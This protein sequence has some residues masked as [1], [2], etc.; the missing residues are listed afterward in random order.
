MSQNNRRTSGSKFT[1]C[2][3]ASKIRQLEKD[4]R[5]M[6][7]NNRRTSGSKF[8]GCTKA[9][10]IRQLESALDYAHRA[11]RSLN[12][13][14]RK[15]GIENDV[16]R[17]GLQDENRVLTEEQRNAELLLKKQDEG[18][19]KAKLQELKLQKVFIQHLLNAVLEKC[20]AESQTCSPSTKSI[21][22]ECTTECAEADVQAT[23]EVTVVSVETQT[24]AVP[25]RHQSRAVRAWQSFCGQG[26]D[27]RKMSQ[28]NRRT[29]GSKFT[30]CPKASKIRQLESALDYAHRAIRSLNKELRK[31]G[32]ENDVLRSGLQDENRVLTEEQRNAELLLK[33][34]DEGRKKAKLQELK[35]Q[36]VFIQ[37]LLNAVLEKV[38]ATSAPA[39]AER[40]EKDLGSSCGKLQ[41]EREAFVSQIAEQTKSNAA[42]DALLAELKRQIGQTKTRPHCTAE[43]QT[44]SPS[45]KS[46]GSECTTECAEADVQATCEVTVVVL[47]EEQRNAELLLKKQDEGRKKAKLQELKLQKVF[48]QHL[49]NAVLEKVLATSAPA[50]AERMEKDLGSSC[51][52]LQE[53]REAFV[54]QIAEQTKSNAAKDALLAEL[55]RQIGTRPHCTAESQTCSPS[56]KSIG[57][58]C[59]TE[60][61]E[62]DVQATSEVTVVSVETQTDAV[63]K[64]H[65]NRAVRAWQSFCGHGKDCRKM[66]Q[67]NRRTSKSKFT[68]CPKASKIRQLES[69]LDYAHR[70]IRSLNKDLRKLGIENDVLR[71]GLQDENRVLTEEQRNAELLLKKQDEGRK[72]AR[73]QELKLQKVFIQHLLNARHQNRAV[74]AWQSFCGQESALDYAHRAIRSLN[75]DVRKLGI[76]PIHLYFKR[77]LTEEQ[78]NVELLLKK[79]DEGRKKAKLQE[80][81]LQKVFIQHLLN[82][83]LEKVLATSAP[84]L[85]ERKEKDLGSS[86]GKLQEEREAFVS[87]IAEQTKS[88]AAKDAL[89][90]ELKRQIGQTKTRPHCTAESQTCSPSTESIGTECN[91]E[92]AEADVQATSEV[93]VVS[94]ETQTDAVPKRHQNRA[95]RAWQSFCGQG[96]DC[97]KMSQNNRRTSGSKFTGCPKASKIRQ[98]ES[99]LDYAHRAI[100]SLN[101]ELRKLGIENDVLR[102]GLQDENRVLTEE[103][104]NAELLLK[105]QDEGRKKAKLQELEKTVEKCRK[106]TGGQVDPSLPDA[107]KESALDYAHRAIRS[108]NKDLRKLG[109]ENDVL[110]SGLQD[111]NRVL[112]EEQRNAELL[113][114]KQDEGRK[115]AKLQE[116]KLQKVFIQHLLNAVLEKVLATSAPALAERKEKDLGST[117]GK[118]KE[119]R[120]AF[121]SQIAEQTKSNAAK[122]ALLAELKRQIGQTK[123]RPHVLATSAPALAERKEKDPGSSCGKLQE[124]REAFVSQIAEQTK[125]NAA[126]DALLAELKRQIGQTKTR[127]HCTAESQTCSP[128]TKSIG[129]KCTTECSEADVQATSEVTVV[130]V[131]TQTDAVPKRHQNRAVRAWQSFCGQ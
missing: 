64:R 89:L 77:V 55:K 15:L 87:Q 100:R 42:K 96:K 76:A 122:D 3:K 16:L 130:S 66:L 11:I 50:L 60:C 126:K 123:T 25:K 117:C 43:S 79:Q 41:E 98:L 59:T 45:T 83:V 6:S 62:A 46:I 86:C 131:E 24:D 47:T 13:E 27:C 88:N 23:S 18:R 99:A 19:K 21:G 81:K 73:L 108:L 90:A 57:S 26:K 72:K 109:I 110:R 29:S 104:R 67:N 101:K 94:V 103:Q 35:L 80:L 12:K 116:L 92:C 74:R 22:S 107:R 44:C 93:T 106:T 17:S 54:S 91:N 85:A 97:R 30:G 129:S 8:T 102:S 78:R 31:L 53:E 52:K 112:T 75:K 113:F 5:K 124:E 71:S 120:E 125:S 39:L 114:K 20:T 61:A 127:P 36:K 121:V 68:G 69:A 28:N 40:M 34:Q 51:G 82:A 84:A 37:H 49:L 7:Q 119:E 9:S 58:E 65:Q 115:K 38:L 2:P 32:I 105:K 111:E 1:G 118:L 56:T 128:S 33:K 48:I 63:P 14:H 10:K 4:C 95:V 70:A